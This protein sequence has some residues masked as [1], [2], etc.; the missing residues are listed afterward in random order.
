M[1]EKVQK[2]KKK[3]RIHNGSHRKKYGKFNLKFSRV[4]FGLPQSCITALAA[5]ADVDSVAR[6]VC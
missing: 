1:Q 4:L 5:G 2:A 3:S 6:V